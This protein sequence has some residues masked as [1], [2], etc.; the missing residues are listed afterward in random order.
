MAFII[1]I[2]SVKCRSH[3]AGAQRQIVGGPHGRYEYGHRFLPPDAA[4][5]HLHLLSHL[6]G[7][8]GRRRRL[9]QSELEG[10]E[11]AEGRLPDRRQRHGKVD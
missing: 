4:P 6:Y 3:S 8:P 5:E 9:V 7:L 1:K 10:N 11:E 2:G